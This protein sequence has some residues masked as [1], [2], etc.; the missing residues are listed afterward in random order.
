M[1]IK[2]RSATR[3][4]D[5]T[6]MTVNGKEITE[7]K[8]KRNLHIFIMFFL[9][10]FVAMLIFALVMLVNQSNHPGEFVYYVKEEIHV[11]EA[12]YHITVIDREQKYGDAIS[13]QVDY[14]ENSAIP[15][16]TV[17]VSNFKKTTKNGE[18]RYTFT[19]K[20]IGENWDKVDGV[21]HVHMRTENGLHEL[22]QTTLAEN[23]WVAFLVVGIFIAILTTLIVLNGKWAVREHKNAKEELN[24][25]IAATQRAVAGYK[26]PQEQPAQEE[27]ISQQGLEPEIGP[28][29]VPQNTEESELTIRCP[30]CNTSN[31]FSSSKCKNCDAPL[32]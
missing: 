19:V 12:T 29:Y 25:K 1:K 3:L 5:G 7:P 16:P 11:E 6:R 17:D 18:V 20:I 4:G 24:E 14:S 30:Y 26:N 27:P 9:G 28:E 2:I 21:G 13:F 15:V 22:E 23:M 10:F 32:R 31:D 8:Q